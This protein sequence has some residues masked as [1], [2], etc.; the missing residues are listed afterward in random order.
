MT[1]EEKHLAE[2]VND[3]KNEPNEPFE[4]FE[5]TEKEVINILETFK[6]KLKK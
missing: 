1:I 5:Y 3:P 6:E 2:W 4:F